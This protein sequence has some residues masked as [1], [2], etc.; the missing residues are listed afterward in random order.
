MPNPLLAPVMSTTLSSTAGGWRTSIVVAVSQRHQSLIISHIRMIEAASK[1]IF[2]IGEMLID[3]K[4]IF[5]KRQYV[6]ACIPVIQL[7]PGR[8]PPAT[9]QISCWHPGEE[10]STSRS[11]NRL[12]YSTCPS[13][14]SCSPEPWKRYSHPAAPPS[15]FRYVASNR[16]AEFHKGGGEVGP[17]DRTHHPPQGRRQV[18]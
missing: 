8:I 6:F 1:N 11:L 2:K 10:S 4:Q 12:R 13:T 7:L 17:H 15:S 16:G 18:E 3:S 5:W 9:T 14:S